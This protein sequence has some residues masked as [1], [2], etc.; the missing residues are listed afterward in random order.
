M[1]F[2]FC[3]HYAMGPFKDTAVK[4]AHASGGGNVGFSCTGAINNT[5][6]FKL[7][8]NNVYRIKVGRKDADGTSW[9]K[10]N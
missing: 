1:I 4:P 8:H 6:C 3:G 5:N 2:D 9:R 7:D 10:V